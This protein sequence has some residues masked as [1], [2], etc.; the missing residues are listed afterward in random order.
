MGS[1]YDPVNQSLYFTEY[2][3]GEVTRLNTGNNALTTLHTGLVG[4]GSRR[5]PPAE[6]ILRLVAARTSARSEPP[7]SARFDLLHGVFEKL[8][9]SGAGVHPPTQGLES[10]AGV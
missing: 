6:R 7:S 10:A 2:S 8:E 5:H 1:G 4:P 9:R 3:S